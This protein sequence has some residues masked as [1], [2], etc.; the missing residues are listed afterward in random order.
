[1][2]LYYFLVVLR[3][4]LGLEA[5]EGIRRKRARVRLD[6][7]ASEETI[8]PAATAVEIKNADIPKASLKQHELA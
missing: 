2:S 7:F 1:M 4:A 5:G 3:G 6:E 8:Q